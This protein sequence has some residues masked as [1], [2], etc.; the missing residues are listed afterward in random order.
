MVFRERLDSPISRPVVM[1]VG[2]ALSLHAVHGVSSVKPT[3][4]GVAEAHTK[5]TVLT[6]NPLRSV[7]GLA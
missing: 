5:D 3:A 2:A 7:F 4:A 6:R 1:A